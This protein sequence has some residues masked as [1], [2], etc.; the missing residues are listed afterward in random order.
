[1]TELRASGRRL[2]GYSRIA[3][4]VWRPCQFRPTVEARD[5]G[6]AGWAL[7]RTF[8]NPGPGP[9]APARSRSPGRLRRPALEGGGLRRGAL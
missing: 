3:A 2:Q 9:G 8:A 1:V 4:P 7:P 5:R 6:S